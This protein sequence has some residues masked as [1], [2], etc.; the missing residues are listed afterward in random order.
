MKK[1][2]VVKVTWELEIAVSATRAI[3]MDKLNAALS[4]ATASLAKQLSK[5][6]KFTP[7]AGRLT[8]RIK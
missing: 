2:V 4:T 8:T 6:M 7:I 5:T 1:D 3:N